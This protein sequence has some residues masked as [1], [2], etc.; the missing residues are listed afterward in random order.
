MD[1]FK[2]LMK[3]LQAWLLWFVVTAVGAA[4]GLIMTLTTAQLAG[5]LLPAE[6]SA[7]LGS[8]MGGALMGLVQWL[9]LRPV[10]KGVPGWL[11]ATGLGWAAALVIVT[12][13][14]LVTDLVAVW[15]MGAAGGSFILG[16]AQWLALDATQMRR[17]EWWLVT[18]IGW[19]AAWGWAT[20]LGPGDGPATFAG[21][22]I[23]AA[24]A[25]TTGLVLIGIVA[26]ATLVLLFP[27]FWKRTREDLDPDGSDSGD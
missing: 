4:L 20:L 9:F 27:R 18:A 15:V 25:G 8:I 6:V 2:S 11:L 1:G 26:L 17:G 5:A 21:G 14:G 12:L 16:L 22:L 19:T 23:G 10:P 24:V 13:P 3:E 7:L